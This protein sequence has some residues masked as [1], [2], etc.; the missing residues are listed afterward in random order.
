MNP[1]NFYSWKMYVDLLSV[2]S[3][4]SRSTEGTVVPLIQLDPGLFSFLYFINNNETN[5]VSN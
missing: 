4:I 1:F 5:L 2:H 3:F